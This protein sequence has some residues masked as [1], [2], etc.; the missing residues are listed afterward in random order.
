MAKRIDVLS[1]LPD[2]HR[3]KIPT[4][5]GKGFNTR[6][7]SADGSINLSTRQAQEVAHGKKSL[8]DAIFTSEGGKKVPNRLKIPSTT[9]EMK[10][11][12]KMRNALKN[13]STLKGKKIFISVRGEAIGEM[14]QQEGDTKGKWTTPLPISKSWETDKYW[15]KV[16]DRIGQ[17]YKG[18]PDLYSV[19]IIGE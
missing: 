10:D 7:V 15:E 16:I 3:E 11:F 5:T 19:T 12:F 8:T 18:D 13:S 4:K 1:Y 9:Y 14:Y 6:F 17:T 2:F